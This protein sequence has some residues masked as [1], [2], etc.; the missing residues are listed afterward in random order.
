MAGSKEARNKALV[1]K[2]FEMLFNK[3]RSAPSLFV[4]T[5]IVLTHLSF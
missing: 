4:A 3:Q 5:I 2:P 1:L